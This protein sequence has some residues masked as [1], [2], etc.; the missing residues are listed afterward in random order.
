MTM[1]TPTAALLGPPTVLTTSTTT[2]ATT[3]HLQVVAP[4]IQ[5]ADDEVYKVSKE[6]KETVQELCATMLDML[7]RMLEGSRYTIPDTT[8]PAAGVELTMAVV[9][10]RSSSTS[11]APMEQKVALEAVSTKHGGT[12]DL[13]NATP[14]KYSTS[15][16]DVNVDT[17]LVAGML[18]PM[19][20]TPHV[21][22]A[23]IGD[24]IIE[25]SIHGTYHL[26]T[27]IPTM[28]RVK[29]STFSLDVNDDTDPA[30]KA[31]LL[32]TGLWY[33]P[34]AFE[35]FHGTSDM[36]RMENAHWILGA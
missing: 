34:N 31:F 15:V 12:S 5:D 10:P 8:S 3:T 9:Y 23:L 26:N 28:A 16:L 21:I 29:C 30:S 35:V 25:S 1:P 20:D 7:N 2:R 17:N 33:N 13:P 14:I 32:T 36:R 24:L 27:D 22:P 6:P 18:L 11:A 19:T 4:P